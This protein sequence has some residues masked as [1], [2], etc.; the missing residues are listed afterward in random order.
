MR[1]AGIKPITIALK[2]DMDDA[3]KQALAE[4]NEMASKVA[5]AYSKLGTLK[6]AAMSRLS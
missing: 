6:L 1:G 2:V 3:N 5:G 4:A